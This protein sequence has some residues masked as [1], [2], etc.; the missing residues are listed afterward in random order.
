M[1]I[2]FETV[3]VTVLWVRVLLDENQ[4]LEISVLQQSPSNHVWWLTGV[5]YHSSS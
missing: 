5:S 3:H 4:N 1:G 2:N